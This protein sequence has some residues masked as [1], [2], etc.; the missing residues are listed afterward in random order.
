M[1][2]Q[3]CSARRRRRNLDSGDGRAK[4]RRAKKKEEND[5]DKCFKKIVKSSRKKKL[6]NNA[7]SG[8]I[9]WEQNVGLNN[10]RK[11]QDM[12]KATEP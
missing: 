10:E 4:T 7:R 12:V 8:R 2:C 11:S 5:R 9:Q 3:L 6:V 1:W